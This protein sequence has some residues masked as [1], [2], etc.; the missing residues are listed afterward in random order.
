MIRVK[1]NPEL[2]H[3]ARERSGIAQEV[4]AEKFKK[5]PDWEDGEAQPTLKQVEAFAHAVHVPV[6][7]L[8]L[9]DPPQESIPISDFRTI[10]GKAVRRPSPNLLDT[11]YTCQEQQSWY[12]DFVLI[13]RQPKLDFVG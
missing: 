1:I 3:W 13:T 6:G 10:A 11:I 8:F 7:Y 2:L 9:T 5:L 4:L 12:R